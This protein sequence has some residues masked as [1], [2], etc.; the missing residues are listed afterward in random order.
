MNDHTNEYGFDAFDFRD[1]V[2]ISKEKINEW[3]KKTEDLLRN[4][5]NSKDFHTISSG[6]TI[7]VS[8][9]MDDE[10]VTIISKSY[11]EKT[12]SC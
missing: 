8:M 3:V 7:V 10:I 5:K 9:K 6:N 2:D 1:G 11:V 12:S 4:S